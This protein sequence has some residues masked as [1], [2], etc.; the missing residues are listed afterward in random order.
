MPPASWLFL[1]RN[2][3]PLAAF[4]SS[5]GRWHLPLREDEISPHLL[6]AIVAVEDSRF[7]QHHGVDWAATF[8]AAKENLFAGRVVRGGSTL[9]MQLDRLRDP[10]PRGWHSKITQAIRAAQ[11]ERRL[12]KREILVEYLNRAP[13]GGSLEGAGAAS[14]RYFGK[15]CANLSLGEAA[16]LAGLPQS[17]NRLRPDLHPDA[18]TARRHHVLSRMLTLGQ[19]TPQQF[20]EA[21]AEPLGAVWHSLS[22]DR[23]NLRTADGLLPA[24]LQAK[25]EA[26]GGTIQTC[27][28][29]DIQRSA[30]DLAAQ[31][32][33]EL[34]S[35]GVTAAAVAIVDQKSG[36]CLASVSL[37]S[38]G[39]ERVTTSQLDLTQ[40]QRS[41]G[42][43]LK[44]FIYAAAFDAGIATP[45]TV[46]HD[47]PAAWPGYVPAN[48]DRSFAGEITAAEALARS[49]NIPA[50]VL[51]EQVGVEKAIGVMDAAGISNVARSRKSPGL[52]LAI[53]GAEATPL[54]LARGYAALARDAMRQ[55][56][57][58]L[59]P[60]ACAATLGALA[61]RER[62]L[63]VCREAADIHVAWKTGTSSGH[64]DAWC[65]AVT[66]G[67][68]SIVVWLG[69]A[70]GK[71][72]LAL[73]GQEAAAP[74]ALKLAATL[75]GKNQLDWPQA[76]GLLAKSHSPANAN[77]RLTILSPAPHAVIQS[78][79]DLAAD[80]QRVCLQAAWRS[81]LASGGATDAKVWWFVDGAFV[82]ASAI[83]D[84]VWWS[85]SRGPHEI[86]VTD[87]KGGNASVTVIVR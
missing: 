59:R 3:H 42:S 17:P 73:V 52:S 15:P 71:G 19:I 72:T 84:K 1:D 50:L 55:K 80:Q 75:D 76:I 20:T 81:N 51:L 46:L 13:F 33:F 10:R 48:Y 82:E 53:G 25:A 86:R 16:L 79:P 40:C 34:R 38:R 45:D 77:R 27:Y 54:E 7:E 78:D 30:S 58:N 37:E 4:A 9:T 23:S 8:S 62:T 24:L 14:W 35:S 64:R 44:P 2:N 28:D 57:A 69:N 74:L 66:P 31:Q 60:A 39:N 87:E 61:E 26:P 43:V 32:L 85:A 36:D 68:L 83:S 67:G 11:I 21:D 18:A 12:T 65:A 29:R 70:N 49:R 5:D 63:A 41:T 22:Q 56:N 6:N 47:E